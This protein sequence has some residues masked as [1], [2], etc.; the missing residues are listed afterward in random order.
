MICTPAAG[1][2]AFRGGER[3]IGRGRK[4]GEDGADD[5][6]PP[7]TDSES[8]W[9]KRAGTVSEW[10]SLATRRRDIQRRCGDV[11]R[12]R[13]ER[14]AVIAR[15]GIRRSLPERRPREQCAMT[16]SPRRESKVFELRSEKPRQWKSQRRS[17]MSLR[18]GRLEI[19]WDDCRRIRRTADTPV[20]RFA[21]N[22]DELSIVWSDLEEDR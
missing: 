5:H 16:A 20:D 9:E 4:H 22:V 6:N 3:G 8:V 14:T 1:R 19:S 2:P 12:K 10:R 15:C 18:N 21:E 17:S 7:Q 11:S 13:S